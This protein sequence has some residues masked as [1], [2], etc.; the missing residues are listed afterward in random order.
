MHPGMD[1]YLV[2][3]GGKSTRKV[4]PREGNSVVSSVWEDVLVHAGQ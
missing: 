3:P 1:L 2:G 4:T